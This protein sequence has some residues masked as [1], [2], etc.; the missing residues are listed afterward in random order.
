MILM[1]THNIMQKILG[2][3][4]L[5]LI[6]YCSAASAGT[7]EKIYVKNS[8]DCFRCVREVPSGG[9]VLAGYTADFNQ[10]DTD[11]IILRLDNNGDTIWSFVY[12]GPNNNEDLFYKVAP[13]SDGGFIVGGYSKS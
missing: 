11:G 4:S 7:W 9:Y 12:N 6:I 10:N 3:L 13:T 5:F 2:V 8:T 1:Y